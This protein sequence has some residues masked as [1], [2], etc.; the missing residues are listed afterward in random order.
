[1][2]TEMKDTESRCNEL[3]ALE[4]EIEGEEEVKKTEECDL[5]YYERLWEIDLM[6][7]QLRF[8]GSQ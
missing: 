7:H 1:M 2:S 5:V 8:L 3:E 6:N 4:S